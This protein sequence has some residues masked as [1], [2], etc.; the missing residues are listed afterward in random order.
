MY[1]ATPPISLGSLDRLGQ[2]S[3]FSSELNLIQISAHGLIIM[4]QHPTPIGAHELAVYSIQ[5]EGETEGREC[6]CVWEKTW[7]RGC[8]RW[9]RH[10]AETETRMDPLQNLKHQ[11]S[12]NNLRLDR[13]H[14]SDS[15]RDNLSPPPPHPRLHL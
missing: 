13:L 6:A 2:C 1:L 8:H 15:E 4:L 10:V 9:K 7:D 5:S 11:K 14:I 12:E 3:K